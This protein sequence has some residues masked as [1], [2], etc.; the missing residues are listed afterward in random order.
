[1]EL[2]YCFVIICKAFICYLTNDSW[3]RTWP[4]M[5]N[6]GCAPRLMCL[7]RM[8][9]WTEPRSRSMSS[10]RRRSP[11]LR[12]TVLLSSSSRRKTNWWEEIWLFCFHLSSAQVHMGWFD[13][14]SSTQGHLDERIKQQEQSVAA[15]QDQTYGYSWILKKIIHLPSE[16]PD[17]CFYIIFQ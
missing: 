16:C 13:W 2:I 12:R 11:E 4:F 9:K 7:P 1:M 10:S 14:L 5:N 15:L 3:C 17:T 8:E 6:S